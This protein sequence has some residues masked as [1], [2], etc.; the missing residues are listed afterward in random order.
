MR[1]FAAKKSQSI[2]SECALSLWKYIQTFYQAAPRGRAEEGHKF[3]A[4]HLQL[5]A[6]FMNEQLLILDVSVY[7]VNYSE[8]SK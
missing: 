4:P 5:A 3:I 8:G 7:S 1:L 6:V 2:L